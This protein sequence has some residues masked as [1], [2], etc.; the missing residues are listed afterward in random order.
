MQTKV[1]V[2]YNDGSDE[3]RRFD[4]M[5]DAIEFLKLCEDR[6]AHEHGAANGEDRFAHHHGPGNGNGRGAWDQSIEDPAIA[7]FE[8]LP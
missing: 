3:I 1:Q 4:T 5:E 8:I 6:F 2:T 7:S